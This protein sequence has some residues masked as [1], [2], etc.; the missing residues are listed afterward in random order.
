VC[1]RARTLTTHVRTACYVAG[2]DAPALNG[3]V[4]GAV[5]KLCGEF[6]EGDRAVGLSEYDL[7]CVGG[8]LV[9]RLFWRWDDLRAPAEMAWFLRCFRCLGCRC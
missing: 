2:G 9:M 1:A 4:S 6:E 3:D 8:V 7:D 5:V